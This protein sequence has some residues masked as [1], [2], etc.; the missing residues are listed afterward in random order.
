[1]FTHKKNILVVEDDPTNLATVSMILEKDGYQVFQAENG[2]K[3]LDILSKSEVNVLVTDL[4]MPN[5][6]GV[7][8]LD[9]TKKNHAL[10]E[11]I[12]ITAHGTVEIAVEAM[13]KGAYDFITKPFRKIDITKTVRQALD[14]YELSAENKILREKLKQI[15]DENKFVGKSLKMKKIIELSMQIAESSSTVLICGDS[16]AGKEVLA[17]MIHNYSPRNS[18]PLVKISCAAIPETLLEGELFGYEKGAFTGAVKSKAGR[19]EIANQG[20]MFLDEIGEIPQSIQVKLLRVLE[21]GVFQRL[22]SNKNIKTDVRIIAATNKDLSEA[23]K[24]K[25]FR[26]DLYYRLN[27]FKIDIPKLAERLEDIPLLVSHFIKKYARKLNKEIIGL[28]REA[29]DIL[30]KHNWPGNVR[31]LENVIEHAC[32]LTKEKIINKHDLSS[33]IQAIEKEGGS[34]NINIPIGTTMGD[35]EKKV[36]LETLR[37]TNGDKTKAANLLGI[38]ARTIY[39]KL[40]E[41]EK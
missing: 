35:I 33:E 36:L 31:E 27:V 29:M 11:V 7:E 20:T 12:L 5:M 18:Q 41:Y 4:K 38:A 9:I 22:G 39:R 2:S 8:L 23:V 17:E 16:G 40:D 1:M 28:S 30:Y 15:E 6:D 19:F 24:N 21:D 10:V 13:K 3:A 37:F 26:E 25:S 32:V 14:K 34:S